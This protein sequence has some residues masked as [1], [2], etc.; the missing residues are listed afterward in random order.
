MQKKTFVQLILILTIIII[1]IAFYQKYFS[2]QKTLN[3]VPKNIIKKESTVSKTKTN[4]IHNIKYTSGDESGDYYVIESELGELNANKPE[5]ILMK[6]VQAEI[7]F[8]DSASIIVSADNAIYNNITYN[9]NF[10]GHVSITY[11]DHI[12]EANNFDLNF[13]KN[14]GTISSNIIYKNLNTKLEA[15]KIKIDL[16]TKNSKIYM[17]GK[18]EK[19]K[20]TN[21]D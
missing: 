1:F 21:I 3:N 4:L 16:I 14:L 9:T 10:Y 2:E 11:T 17:N 8:E 6:K 15:D 12:I 13:E 18:K 19:I 7:N 20:I 5:L